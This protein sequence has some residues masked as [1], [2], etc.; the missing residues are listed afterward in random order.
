MGE[1]LPSKVDRFMTEFTRHQRRLDLYAH[2]LLPRY[3]DAE[4]VMQEALIVLW[5]KFDQF[6]PTRS[7]SA[8]ASRIVYLKAK[9]FRRRS[10]RLV[11]LLDD[12]VF[13]QLAVEVAK[14]PDLLEARREA[15]RRCADCLNPSD[16]ELL[17]LRYIPSA[18]IKEVAQRLGRPA[19][20]VCQSLSRIRQA[21]WDCINEE[22]IAD[23]KHKGRDVASPSKEDE[24]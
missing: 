8:W 11:T 14:E 23:E 12:A 7:F 4:D 15:M 22:M 17:D 19:N 6:D 5:E 9:N 1:R 2:A 13:E 20:S 10:S 24:R 18:T 16:R 21:L 3:E